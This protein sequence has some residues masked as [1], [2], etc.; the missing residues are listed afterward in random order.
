MYSSSKY[1]AIVAML[2]FMEIGLNGPKKLTR[3]NIIVHRL[4]RINP[5]ILIASGT[6]IIRARARVESH[7]RIQDMLTF[8]GQLNRSRG[9]G[10]VILV[11]WSIFCLGRSGVV[12]GRLFLSL[13]FAD[14][15]GLR[16]RWIEGLVGRLAKFGGGW[17]SCCLL[18]SVSLLILG[19]RYYVGGRS[20]GR[21]S[22]GIEDVTDYTCVQC[23]CMR[24]LLKCSLWLLVRST[25]VISTSMTLTQ[26][27]R[28][29]RL[30]QIPRK[31][32]K[33]DRAFYSYSFE[34]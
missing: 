20:C 14:L 4:L 18:L 16:D 33:A 2:R 32:S 31:G 1:S 28:F 11:Q 26:D 7:D 12:I 9:V 27:R 19:V 3:C 23:P 8:R 24:A 6:F 30:L 5:Y 10:L 22:N 21:K 15:V 13:S 25:N 29:V 17:H 34:P